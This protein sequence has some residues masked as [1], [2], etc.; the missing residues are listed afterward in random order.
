MFADF[1]QE[2]ET[3]LWLLG[4]VSV[5]TFIGSLIIV[6]WLII[7]IPPDYFASTERRRSITTQRHPILRLILV[8]AKN[9]TGT[10]LIVM[11][12]AMLVLPGQGILTILMGIL[13]VDFPNKYGFERWL[14]QTKPIAKTINAIRKR[15]GSHPLRFRLE[16]AKSGFEDTP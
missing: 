6:P 4:L 1:I 15:A 7:R 2:N 3:F 14:V 8:L 16:P 13:M 12:I 11:G 9:L 5:F 10:I